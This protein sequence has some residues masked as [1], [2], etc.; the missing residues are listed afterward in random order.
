MRRIADSGL[1]WDASASYGAHESDFFFRN[2]VNASLGPDTPRDFDPGLYR[3]EDVNLNV[4]VSYPVSEMVN[5]AAGAEWR[6][7]SFETGAGGRPSWEVGPYAAQGFIPASNG[8]PGFPDYTA[9][10]FGGAASYPVSRM[11]TRDDEGGRLA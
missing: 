9:G 5:V 8:F 7:E 4:D 6:D 10:T 3:Q 11:R 2:T 1:T